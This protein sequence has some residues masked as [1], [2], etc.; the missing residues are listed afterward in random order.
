QIEVIAAFWAQVLLDRGAFDKSIPPHVRERVSAYAR[1]PKIGAPLKDFEKT[2]REAAGLNDSQLKQLRD[3]LYATLTEQDAYGLA[4]LKPSALALSLAFDEPWQRCATCGNL[5]HAPLLGRCAICG[6][7]QLEP[8]GP[9]DPAISARYDYYRAPLRDILHGVRPAHLSAEEHTA[10]LSQRDTAAVYATTEE[11]ELRFQD[12]VLGEDRPPVD[13]LSCTTT[14]EV[15][16][17]IGSLVAIGMRNI[18]PQREN[19]QQRA[20]RAGRRGS[21]VST[22]VAY[23]D[24]GPH[25][26]FYF[27]HPEGMIAGAPRRPLL[28]I[29]R[30]TLVRRHIYAYLIQTFFHAQ[31]RALTPSELAGLEHERTNLFTALGT[32]SEF[33]TGH[34]QLS[35]T[36]FSAWVDARVVAHG[37][38]IAG[39]AADWI[40]DVAVPGGRATKTSF[41]VDAAQA[42]IGQLQKLSTTGQQQDTDTTDQDDEADRGGLLNTLFD[43]GLLPTYAFPT[44]LA[45][46]YVFE[47]DGD[48]VRVKERP[49]QSKAQALSEYAPGRLLVVNK[50]TYRVGGIHVQNMGYDEPVRGLFAR[51]LPTYTYCSACTYVRFEPLHGIERCPICQSELKSSE[52]LDPPGFSP[53]KGEPVGERDRDQEISYAAGA[54]LP[55][56]IAP[57]EL[58]W[59][60]GPWSNLRYAYA[61]GQRFV[62]MNRGPDE[63][64]FAVCESC[65]AAW[66]SADAPRGGAHSRPYLV[67]PRIGSS[68]CRGPIHS[69]PIYLG[70]TFRSDL[71]LMRCTIANPLGDSPRDPWLQDALRTAAEALALAASRLLDVDPSELSAGHRLLPPDSGANFDLY[72][73]DTASGGAGYASEAGAEL[74]AILQAALDLVEGCPRRCERS[75][76]RCLRHYGNRFWHSSLDR[77]LAAQVLRHVMYGTT[78]EVAPVAEQRRQ[79]TALRRFLELE[80]W[81]ITPESADAPLIAGWGGHQIVVGTYPSLLD[82]QAP[83]FSHPLGVGAL[84]LRDYVVARDLPAAYADLR[85]AVGR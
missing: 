5:Q 34:S 25:D 74:D 23:A 60:D 22:V 10:Q 27:Q 78:P 69:S 19:Y 39:R 6:G 68:Q 42:L 2:I 15:G 75:C 61:E 20:G 46:F 37:G 54:Q 81:E 84:L 24:S 11:F 21:A 7:Q 71:L 56:P 4:Y 32:R 12:I 48:K 16:I 3:A 63:Q 55:L 66:P 50:K 76:T 1:P 30:Q 40:P 36:A 72:L 83:G 82:P 62:I 17:D 70:T 45:S 44:D 13:V 77:H 43:A 73:F 79:L 29:D 67:P 57:D 14:M 80:G 26:H 52:L 51:P 38:D 31:L 41:V 53:E 59:R 9:D 8:R 64:G 35:L 18:P 65:G 49:Q 58:D 33:F 47:R 85:R 28:S